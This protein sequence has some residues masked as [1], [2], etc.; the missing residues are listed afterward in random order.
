MILM[1]AQ[2]TRAQATQVRVTRLGGSFTT[3]RGIATV[4]SAS[5]RLPE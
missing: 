1:Q 3:H 4:V 5:E 2:A